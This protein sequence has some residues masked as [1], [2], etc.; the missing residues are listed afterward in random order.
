MAFHK[1]TKVKDP[2]ITRQESEEAAESSASVMENLTNQTSEPYPMDIHAHHLHN[3]PG[4]KIWHYFFEFLMLFLA[5]FCGFM[6]EYYLEHRIERD[7]EKEFVGQAVKEM[8]ADLLQIRNFELDSNRWKYQDTLARLMLGKDLSQQAIRKMY[9]CLWSIDIGMYMLFRQNTLTQ[10]KSAGNMRLIRNTAVADSLYGW[11]GSISN[12]YNEL[13]E[14]KKIS[15]DNYR[16]ACRI[17]DG[18]NFVAN[19]QWISWEETL[20]KKQDV[21]LMTTDEK[22]FHELGNNMFRQTNMRHNYDNDINAHKKYTIRLIDFFIKQ[23]HLK[24]V[25][26]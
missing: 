12:S 7:R 19:G 20:G 22:L 17:F 5:V 4:E 6:A 18:G 24:E 9:Q 16:L 8:K 26:P 13:N 23:Y 1:K 3:A 21:N 25:Y 2:E 11:D 15:Y 14:L 10:L